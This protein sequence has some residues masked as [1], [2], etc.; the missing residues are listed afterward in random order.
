[1]YVYIYTYNYKTCFCYRT[2][3]C[4]DYQTQLH[5]KSINTVANVTQSSNSSV[6][7][8]IVSNFVFVFASNNSIFLKHSERVIRFY[9]F[10]VSF[11]AATKEVSTKKLSF[12]FSIK[13]KL[14]LSEAIYD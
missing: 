2:T 9:T 13:S 6:L 4:S 8:T 5:S 1:M 12:K 10:H 14:I 11:M 7:I 3:E